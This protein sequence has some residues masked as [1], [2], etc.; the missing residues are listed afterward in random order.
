[1]AILDTK[2]SHLFED[3]KIADEALVKALKVAANIDPLNKVAF[4]N[5]RKAVETAEAHCDALRK[6]IQESRLDK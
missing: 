4:G 3:L 6:K 2:D 1:M 5:A